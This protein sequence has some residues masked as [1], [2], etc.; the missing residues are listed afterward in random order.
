VIGIRELF[1]TETV[2]RSESRACALGNVALLVGQRLD[3][4]R[5]AATDAQNSRALLE[6]A[7]RLRHAA[8]DAG[9]VAEVAAAQAWS[10]TAEVEDWAPR[11]TTLLTLDA[12]DPRV[13]PRRA[14]RS[15]RS[16]PRGAAGSERSA[17]RTPNACATRRRRA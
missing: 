8:D 1:A 14:A 5:R 9:R 2:D 6:T 13:R 17:P 15:A 10:M 7:P 11:R 4:I 12:T 3:I 16:V